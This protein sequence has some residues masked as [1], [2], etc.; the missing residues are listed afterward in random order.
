MTKHGLPL[1]PQQC[2]TASPLASPAIAGAPGHPAALKSWRESLRPSPHPEAD[3]CWVCCTVENQVFVFATHSWDL[4]NQL[5]VTARHQTPYKIKK[6]GCQSSLERRRKAPP[7]PTPKHTMAKR[8]KFHARHWIVSCYHSRDD[9]SE[10][11]H[12][13]PIYLHWR[14]FTDMDGLGCRFVRRLLVHQE[15]HQAQQVHPRR[16]ASILAALA[17]WFRFGGGSEE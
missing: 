8:H 2:T 6:C 9:D 5:Q 14:G 13:W 1:T 15:V 10:T 4:P 7:K 12:V 3:N 11:I 17:C 16:G